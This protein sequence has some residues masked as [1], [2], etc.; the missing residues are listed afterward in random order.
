MVLLAPPVVNFESPWLLLAP[1]GSSIYDFCTSCWLLLAPP[2]TSWHLL[3]PAPPPNS[4]TYD[5]RVLLAPPGSTWL[6]LAPP[7]PSWLLL[8]PPVV[9]F[10]S[11]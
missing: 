5:R 2:G 1:H 9:I 3:A 8:A 10:E 4:S 7:G 11:S 6:L